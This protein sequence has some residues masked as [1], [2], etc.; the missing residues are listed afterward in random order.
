[1]ETLFRDVIRFFSV[2]NKSITLPWNEQF[3]IIVKN[4]LSKICELG[5]NNTTEMKISKYSFA[6]NTM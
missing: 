3:R 1:M 4:I 2:L 6:C 5:R